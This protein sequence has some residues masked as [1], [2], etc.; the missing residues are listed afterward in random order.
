MSPFLRETV[1]CDRSSGRIIAKPAVLEELNIFRRY[2]ISELK[3]R[4]LHR[5]TSTFYEVASVVLR[6]YIL[7]SEGEK[8]AKV[9]TSLAL[10]R[11]AFSSR[12]VPPATNGQYEDRLRIVSLGSVSSKLAP[13][14][15]LEFSWRRQPKRKRR[16]RSSTTRGELVC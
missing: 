12:S 10:L 9:L 14:G 1:T 7:F 15:F 6:S 8:I 2:T 5:D 16:R 13:L 11:S 4:L 3:M